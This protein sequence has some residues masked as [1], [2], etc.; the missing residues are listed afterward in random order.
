[1]YIY[2]CVGAVR[3]ARLHT[4]YLFVYTQT[5]GDMD[6]S[7]YMYVCQRMYKGLLQMSCHSYLPSKAGPWKPNR[8]DM[9]AVRTLPGGASASCPIY[10][11]V[12]EHVNMDSYV[13]GTSRAPLS[14][15]SRIASV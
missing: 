6:M 4:M 1:M 14:V 13:Y 7:T 2:I 11:A 10:I 3:S 5:Q 12:H 8:N 9:P 15:P